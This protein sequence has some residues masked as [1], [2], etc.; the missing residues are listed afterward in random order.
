MVEAISFQRILNNA[1]ILPSLW[2]L[3]GNFACVA[4]MRRLASTGASRLDWFVTCEGKWSIPRWGAALILWPGFLVGFK[5]HESAFF[6]REKRF[7]TCGITRVE[8]IFSSG[9]LASALLRG[10]ALATAGKTD[11]S[12]A[13]SGT[14][15]TRNYES[16]LQLLHRQSKAKQTAIDNSEEISR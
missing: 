13:P 15:K 7:A 8:I 11:I 9:S 16:K 2:L 5:W 12:T 3:L 1:I 6:R 14:L 4:H 10:S